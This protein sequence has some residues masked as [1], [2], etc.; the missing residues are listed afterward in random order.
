MKAQEIKSLKKQGKTIPQIAK[1]TGLTVKQVEYKLYRQKET[2]KEQLS[3]NENLEI[4]RLFRNGVKV[5]ELSKKFNVTPE[6][7]RN[8]VREYLPLS[9]K[10]GV[11]H[12]KRLNDKNK[13]EIEK[14]Y[15]KGVKLTDIAEKLSIPKEN[16]VAYISRHG[17]AD[18]KKPTTEITKELK[19][20]FNE[21]YQNGMNLSQIA[22]KYKTTPQTVKKYIKNY[23][24]VQEP[25]TVTEEM[26]NDFVE[27]YYQGIK[28]LEIAKRFK[29]S[30]Q[31]VYKHLKKKGVFIG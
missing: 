24:R 31:T 26:A 27:L 3:K 12:V 10:A 13:K 11:P 2:V 4:K 8:K 14:L 9:P 15:K 20:Q 17:L 1:L 25:F 16:V 29:T 28:V 23:K 19:K 30:K 18:R 7:I 21:D 22:R 5:S 6:T